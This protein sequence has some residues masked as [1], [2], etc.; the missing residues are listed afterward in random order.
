MDEV[1]GAWFD[2]CEQLK[3]GFHEQGCAIELGLE[4]AALV[5]VFR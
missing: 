2:R 3:A 4:W 1:S 5:S